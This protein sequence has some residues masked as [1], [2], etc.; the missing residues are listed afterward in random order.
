MAQPRREDSVSTTT[1]ERK[2]KQALSGT[3]PEGGEGMDCSG[4]PQVRGWE[5]AP[6]SGQTAGRGSRLPWAQHRAPQSPG[7]RKILDA[8][9]GWKWVKGGMF[10]IRG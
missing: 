3:Q 8:E 5:G 2:G 7:G 10:E 4:Q 1:I 9:A 6:V